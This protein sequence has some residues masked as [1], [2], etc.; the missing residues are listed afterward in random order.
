MSVEDE[1]VPE[2]TEFNL[3]NLAPLTCLSDLEVANLDI[4]D[5]HTMH[6]L[7]AITSLR[8]L[9]ARDFGNLYRA[10]PESILLDAPMPRLREFRLSFSMKFITGVGEYS[11]RYE[12]AIDWVLKKGAVAFPG[13]EMLHL[14]VLQFQ[15]PLDANLFTVYEAAHSMNARVYHLLVS[16]LNLNCVVIEQAGLL[17]QG[18]E[19]GELGDAL[20]EETPILTGGS[21]RVQWQR[22]V[23]LEVTQGAIRALEAQFRYT[24][25]GKM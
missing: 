3:C 25:T 14:G 11:P 15:G 5:W 22:I 7:T 20:E 13:I 8:L 16:A 23:S 17:D 18:I 4:Y 19:I 10:L 12:E 6:S 9:E 1:R 2:D 24:H 21:R